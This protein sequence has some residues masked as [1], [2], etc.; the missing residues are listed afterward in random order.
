VIPQ[1]RAFP[2]FII[3]DLKV[4][5]SLYSLRSLK[6]GGSAGLCHTLTVQRRWAGQLSHKKGAFYSQRGRAKAITGR[7]SNQP[8]DGGGCGLLR[9]GVAH[10]AHFPYMGVSRQ[11]TWRSLVDQGIPGLDPG[12]KFSVA[13]PTKTEIL[14]FRG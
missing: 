9:H 6:G 10:P 7:V 2:E 13:P 14:G 4:T 3:W 5:V 11:D 12:F 8:Q 1:R